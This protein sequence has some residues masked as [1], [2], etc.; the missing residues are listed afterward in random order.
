MSD[1][2]AISDQRRKIGNI[3][4]ALTQQASIL[5][6]GIA[7]NIDD[8]ELSSICSVFAEYFNS[9]IHQINLYLAIPGVTEEEPYYQEKVRKYTEFQAKSQLFHSFKNCKQS[10]QVWT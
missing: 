4:R 8:Q 7:T 10:M 9:F 2:Q 1:T 3:Q 6:H 5:Q